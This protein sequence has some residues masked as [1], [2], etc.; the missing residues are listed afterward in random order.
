[1]EVRA[2][3]L[4]AGRWTPASTLAR[5]VAPPL[6]V[7][8]SDAQTVA[9]VVAATPVDAVSGAIAAVVWPQRRRTADG[10]VD[11]VAAAVWDATLGW[12]PGRTVSRPPG[13]EA[14]VPAV[15]ADDSGRIVVAWES[16]IGDRQT[17][18]VATLSP[19]RSGARAPECCADLVP[20]GQEASA[21]ALATT[22]DSTVAVWVGTSRGSIE[23]ADLPV[24][25][26]C[27]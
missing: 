20:A 27:A 9:P 19:S 7:S 17:A 5:D 22:S 8:R 6:G 1:M 18:R 25:A 23:A 24:A 4:D 3:V 11:E 12:S 2:R 15:A 26:T 14:G 21:P 10:P 16:L 13:E